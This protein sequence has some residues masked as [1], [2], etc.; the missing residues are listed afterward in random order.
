VA[1]EVPTAWVVDQDIPEDVLKA[2]SPIKE[3][4]AIACVNCRKPT[5]SVLW[6]WWR[7]NPKQQSRIHVCFGC[8]PLAE[9]LLVDNGWFLVRMAKW[10]A[11]PR[12]GS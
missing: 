1:I 9:A 5:L 4:N 2:Y 11:T 3:A 8:S 12:K 7:N 6:L 10:R